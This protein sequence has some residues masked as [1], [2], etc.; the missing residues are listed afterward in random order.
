MTARPT[1]QVGSTGDE[2]TTV[3]TCLKVPPVDGSFG[4]RTERAV[5]QFQVDQKLKPDGIV[6][7]KTWD[8]LEHVYR[9]PPYVPPPPADEGRRR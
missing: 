6:G 3:Q 4:D 1:I 8:A 2:V 7:P 5:R 9:L